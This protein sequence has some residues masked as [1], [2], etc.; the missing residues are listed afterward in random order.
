MGFGVVY[1]E[2]LCLE[3]YLKN[4]KQLISLRKKA[5]ISLEDC[6]KDDA[7]SEVSLALISLLGGIPSNINSI[8][9]ILDK[10]Q[11]LY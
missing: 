7:L 6:E 8:H 4:I 11:L 1:Q 10:E 3:Q 5:L 9:E 2:C